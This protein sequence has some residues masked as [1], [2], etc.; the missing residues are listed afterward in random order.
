MVCATTAEGEFWTKYT[1]FTELENLLDPQ[2]FMRIHRQVMI[3]LD[4]VREI[5]AYDKHSARLI[6]TTGQEVTVSR[7]HLKMRRRALNL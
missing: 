3:N 6:L 2:V 7:S 5:A 1:T 4:H